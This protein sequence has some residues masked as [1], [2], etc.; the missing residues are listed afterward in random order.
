VRVGALWRRHEVKLADF[1]WSWGE[2]GNK[3]LDPEK[4]RQIA[5]Q[6]PDKKVGGAFLVDGVRVEGGR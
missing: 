4:V 2:G 6:Q 1:K 3:A 5:F